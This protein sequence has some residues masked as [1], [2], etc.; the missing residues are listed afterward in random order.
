[1]R[2]AQRSTR[3]STLVMKVFV[4]L[5]LMMCTSV[6]ADSGK[7]SL[8]ESSIQESA[9]HQFNGPVITVKQAIQSALEKSR[10]L[11]SLNTNVRMAEYL[12]KSSGKLRNPEV[13]LS[14]V[15]AGQIGDRIDEYELG[16]RWRFP[17]PG[18]LGEDRQQAV[19]RLWDRKVDQ[20][21]FQQQLIARVRRSYADVLKSDYLAE[22]AHQRILKEDERIRLIEHMVDL[23]TRSIVYYTKAKMW[24]A[25]SKN[26][27]T[28][29]IEKQGMERRQL[30][31]R[32]G[33]PENASLVETELPEVTQELDEL[34]A[35]AISNR[36]ETALVEQRITLAH[37]RRNYERYQL[38]PRPTFI[39]F[40]R[41]YEK[42]DWNN[43]NEWKIGIEL[44]LFDWNIGNIQA[45][46]LAV[47]K[48]EEEYNAIQESIADEVRVAYV[49]YRDLLLD[50][51]NFKQNADDLIFNAGK[52]VEEAKEHEVLLP[53]E[54]MEM[55]LTIIETK[56]LLSE[57]RRDLA[58][59]LID[60]YYAIGV[61]GHEQL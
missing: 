27:Y 38:L 16:V 17:E 34:I 4:S 10:K 39:E 42:K 45:T 32:S 48:K 3:A 13:R 43:W 59:A 31:Q 22:L 47:R 20:L 61:D 8:N 44:P 6:I 46:D 23:G 57:K 12:V 18:E 14:D 15:N 26:D 54:V 33:I 41:H 35:L 9:P 7:S 2:T 5:Y 58:H 56:K 40:S 1:M 24:H 37:R 55:E 36:P 25:E 52:V 19:V 21:R 49:V 53:D 50:W 51:K 30:A 28:R 60:L 11:Q 29:A